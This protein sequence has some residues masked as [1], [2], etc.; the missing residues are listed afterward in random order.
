MMVL[1]HDIGQA[2][3]WQVT[4]AARAIIPLGIVLGW[5]LATGV[6]LVFFRP[7]VLWMRS[8]AGSLSLVGS[9][10]V[11]PRLPP[12]DVATIANIF[13]IWVALLS[14]PL[15]GEIPSLKVWLAI[16]CGVAGVALTQLPHF[17]EGNLAVLIIVAVSIFTALAMLGLHRLRGI[18]PR[19]IVVHFSFVAAL[20]A[21]AA[22]FLADSPK[23]WSALKDGWRL[24][25]LA[26]IGLTATI[27]QFFLTMAFTHGEPAKIS[28]VGLTQILFTMV[29]QAL[30][31]R[32][33]PPL[34]SL[35]GA[36]LV[37]GPTAWLMWRQRQ[38][39]TVPEIHELEDLPTT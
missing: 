35:L 21:L 12:A 14:W 22:C 31:L 6:R 4:A 17:E 38:D 23:G 18:D 15:L 3:D 11:L 27:G 20:F 24:A 25:E 36:P 33:W 19:A 5:C 9:F 26:A 16:F 32:K 34:H 37:I 10:Y 7:M 29:I 13:P 2:V 28:V 1:S 8:L 39:Q 30:V